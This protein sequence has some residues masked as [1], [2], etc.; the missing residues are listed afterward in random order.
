LEGRKQLYVKEFSRLVRKTKEYGE[1]FDLLQSGS[2]II[3]AE[4]DV[5][6]NG[7]KGEYGKDCDVDN[8]CL[9]TMDKINKLLEDTS[10][11]FGHGLV[12]AKCL[13]EDLE[14]IE[15]N[16]KKKNLTK[17]KVSK[18][19]KYMSNSNDKDKKDNKEINKTKKIKK[20]KS[21]I[22]KQI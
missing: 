21:I 7:K 11:A 15:N 16:L 6:S 3:I 13:L 2:N 12:I 18:A 22:N 9:I 1:L 10:E 8:N 5:P 4:I 20:N 14:Q 19:I 17:S